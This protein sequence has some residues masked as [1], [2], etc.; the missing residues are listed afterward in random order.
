MHVTGRTKAVGAGA[1][2]VTLVAVGGEQYLA[3]WGSRLLPALEV[4]SAR[5]STY[6]AT[7]IFG[8]TAA[9]N[10][11]LRTVP[12]GIGKL[13]E[14][15]TPASY[16]SLVVVENA[17]A[18]ARALT[19]SIAPQL[20]PFARLQ[21]VTQAGDDAF[22]AYGQSSLPRPVIVPNLLAQPYQNVAPSAA[23]NFFS[24]VE[25]TMI[26]DLAA[27]RPLQ[28]D[29]AISAVRR[30]LQSAAQQA[31]KEPA[32][33]VSF[34][35]LTGKLKID[36]S[37]TIAGVKVSGGEINLYTTSMTVGTAAVACNAVADKEFKSCV[38]DATT[39]IFK[40]LSA[41]EKETET[42]AGK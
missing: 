32:A 10:I 5:V 18:S 29:D 31:E 7:E 19:P 11:E 17:P 38:A 30:N 26:D 14:F 20:D 3:N 40:K 27:R 28:L 21:T 25:P 34:E 12:I 42:A 22:A 36:A 2:L 35:V 6:T 37:K 13:R 9:A 33:K 16:S 23:A 41:P 15:G 4:N 1:G 39:K 24:R 8:G